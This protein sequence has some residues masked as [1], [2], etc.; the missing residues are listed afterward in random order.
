MTSETIYAILHEMWQ[1]LLTALDK[2]RHIHV[3]EETDLEWRKIWFITGLSR[4]RLEE[5]TREY[6]ED[7]P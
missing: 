3:T 1:N 2:L 4:Q 6:F 7:E 5:I